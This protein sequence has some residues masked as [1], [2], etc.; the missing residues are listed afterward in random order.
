MGDRV[1]MNE[2]QALT[3]I[4]ENKRWTVPVCQFA[5]HNPVST[6]IAYGQHPPRDE[7]VLSL[8]INEFRGFISTTALSRDESA[9]M[10]ALINPIVASLQARVQREPPE[11]VAPSPLRLLEGKQELVE[12]IVGQ[13]C[14]AD[15]MCAALSCRTLRDAVFHH[16]PLLGGPRTFAS[17]VASSKRFCHEAL[18]PLGWTM[19]V[20]RLRLARDLG[21]FPLD[22][23]KYMHS[24]ATHRVCS[25]AARHGSVST[26]EE[27]YRL[28]YRLDV[29]AYEE[30][31][32]A[33]H[34]HV[35]EWLRALEKVKGG[36]KANAKR[37]AWDESVTAAAAD[38]GSLEVLRWLRYRKCPWDATTCIAAARR[39]Y[40]PV[41]QWA[42]K[43]HCAWD[44]GV[45]LAAVAGPEPNQVDQTGRGGD[46]TLFFW[47]VERG[48]RVHASAHHG[49]RSPL[50][51]GA[52]SAAAALSRS[53]RCLRCLRQR[54]DEPLMTN[55]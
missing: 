51:T 52:W 44:D 5:P 10:L 26:L 41:L 50:P 55:H 37:L 29:S 46:A 38:G 47:C 30:A 35:L 39:G 24:S 7:P 34:L 23:A 14:A 17:G 43:N 53:L 42:R 1:P 3:P 2:S 4:A 16:T 13:L 49:A 20:A 15:A 27:A 45:T 21:G 28:G 54:A 22:D 6:G 11:I 31:A 8:M 9:A 25:C 18:H 32:R 33:G 48:C 40:L 36:P 12:S 19:S